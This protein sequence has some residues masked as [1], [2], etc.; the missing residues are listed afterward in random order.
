M[1]RILIA[2]TLVGLLVACDNQGDVDTSEAAEPSGSAGALA[3]ADASA[4]ASGGASGSASAA[5]EEAFAPLAEMEITSISEFGDLAEEVQPTVESCESVEDWVAG[6][7]GVVEEEVDPDT[8]RFLLSMNCN[9]PALAD[10][11]I[12]EELAAS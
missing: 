5:C 9:D 6:A 7:Q 1:S 11:V 8:A 2:L 12:C 4:G 10:T 3:S